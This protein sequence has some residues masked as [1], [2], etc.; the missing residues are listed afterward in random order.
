MDQSLKRSS[1]CRILLNA[2]LKPK[3]TTSVW[4]EVLKMSLNTIASSSCYTVDA[5]TLE[6]VK[7]LRGEK[8]RD[9]RYLY[10][11]P[12]VLTLYVALSNWK[13]WQSIPIQQVFLLSIHYS[14]SFSQF[15]PIWSG[16]AI[17]I[18]KFYCQSRSLSK[19]LLKL[20]CHF[21]LIKPLVL[22]GLVLIFLRN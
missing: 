2:F 17:M 1:L 15:W 22:M 7:L 5:C 20:I 13:Y 6:K 3:Y 10:N 4:L 11:R 12:V 9:E 16:S 14:W 18:I 19:M 21:V 8:T